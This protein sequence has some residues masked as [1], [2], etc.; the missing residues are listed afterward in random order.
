MAYLYDKRSADADEEEE[1]YSV[2]ESGQHI[3]FSE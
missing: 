2:P 3:K 1:Q